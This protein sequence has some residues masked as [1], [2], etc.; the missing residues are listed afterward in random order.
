[1]LILAVC[2][3]AARFSTHPQ[4]SG[5]PAFLR[6][7]SWAKPARDIALR[8]YD[9]PNI[10]ILT[11]LLILGLHEFGTC[12][13]GRSW[14][15]GGMAVRMAYALQLH[16][17]LEHDPSVRKHDKSTAL[18]FTD[19]E[20]RRRTMWS[21]F[22]MDRFNSS[23]TG[24]PTF[25]SEDDIK[26]QLPIKESHF[27]MEIPGPTEGLNGEVLSPV[28]SDPGHLSDPKENMGIAAYMIR[29]IAI[30]GRVIRYMNLGGKHQDP[31]PW[32]DSRSNFAALK[33]QAKDYQDSLPESLRYN[34][35]NL[36]NHAAEKLANQFLFLHLAHSQV[37]LF[38][39]CFAIPTTPGGKAA[40]E[41]PKEFL[42]EAGHI[43]VEAASQISNVL[44]EATGYLIAAPFA[45]YCAFFSSTVH[46][47]GMFSKNSQLEA[48]SQQ[49][50]ACNVK[51]LSK[52]KK[53]WGMFHYMTE[54]LK[55]SF[56]QYADASSKGSTARGS[57]ERDASV[58][59][60]GD[61]F[62]QYPRGVSDTDYEDP[63]SADNNE[64]G[65]DAVLSQK[66]D[67]QTVKE[68]FDSL[69][70]P[71]TATHHRKVSKR[72][73]KGGIHPDQHL[74]LFPT[75][76][77]TEQEIQQSRH[78]HMSHGLVNMPM[79]NQQQNINPNSYSQELFTPTQ[80][81]FSDPSGYPP[82][83]MALQNP[84]LPFTELE[85]HMV[86]GAYAGTDPTG[87]SSASSLNGLAGSNNHAPNPNNGLWDGMMDYSQALA[88]SQSY[89]DL[90]NSA[91]FMPFN[92]NPPDIGGE[93]EMGSYGLDVN[94]ANGGGDAQ[95]MSGGPV[96]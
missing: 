71:A 74:P 78:N 35:E 23:G 33:K 86:Y 60:Y 9:E 49:N 32:W 56:R 54:N 92:L 81:S 65:N 82:N 3:I 59:Q 88:A 38:L 39:H 67:L 15:L 83:V 73:G 85:R 4:V 21:C 28:S 11:V 37:V 6:G 30:W 45:G 7:E 13:G 90:S 48:S 50:L 8:R 29:I 94:D 1:M 41:M 27:Q 52:M 46:V 51:Y 75:N 84:G 43:A 93:G 72:H 58:F 68:F 34:P 24:R 66:S 10:T 18:S 55:E 25:A 62:D 42:S 69:Q 19:R 64:N 79:H 63:A 95:S 16:K 5:E 17:E 76:I 14:M 87:T 12:Q 2:A 80:S 26:V 91:W 96:P 44:G 53:Y 40:N 77:K 20:I 61:W 57:A 47:W 70:P 31:H 22:L 89:S 36:K